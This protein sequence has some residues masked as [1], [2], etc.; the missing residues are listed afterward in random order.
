[1]Y[2]GENILPKFQERFIFSLNDNEADFL[3]NGISVD[4]LRENIVYY[5]DSVKNTFQIKPYVFPS[6][7]ELKEFLDKRIEKRGEL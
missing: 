6:K 3:G 7:N 4:K 1:M 2:Y 5:T